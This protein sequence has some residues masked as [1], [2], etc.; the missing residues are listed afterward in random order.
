MIEANNG[1][2]NSV[3]FAAYEGIAAFGGNGI[4]PAPGACFG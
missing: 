1:V 2:S 3:I 4:F